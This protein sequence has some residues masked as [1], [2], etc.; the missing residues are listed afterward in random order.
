MKIEKLIL[1]FYKRL[2]LSNTRYFEWTPKSNILLLLG[3]NGAGKSSV[4][5][6][7][8]PCPASKDQFETGGLKEFHC[9]HGGHHYKLVSIYDRGTGKH[10]FLKN[11][12]EELNPGG[13][14]AVQKDLVLEVFGVDRAMH[15]ILIG[16]T[17]FTAM[18]TAKR[19]EVLTRMSP[20]DLTY[21]FSQFNTVKSHQRDAQGVINHKAKR[22]SSENIDLPSDGEMQ[23]HRDQISRLTERLQ[24]LYRV[25]GNEPVQWRR[26]P[27][28]E[29]EYGALRQQGVR[30]LTQQP[31]PPELY[32]LNSQ[33][34]VESLIS[35]ETHKAQAAKGQLEELAHELDELQRQKVP[36]QDFGT[37]EQIQELERELKQKEERLELVYHASNAHDGQWPIVTHDVF[38]HSRGLLAE[39]MSA[40]TTLIQEFPENPNDRFNHQIGTESRQRFA[41][42]KI[43]LDSLSMR[44]NE[45]T[46]RLARLRSCDDVVCPDCTHSFKPGINPGEIAETTEKVTQLAD[47]IAMLEADQAQLKDYIEQYDDYLTYVNR[48]RVLVRQY[49]IYKPIWEKAVERRIM[50]TEPRRYLT[51]VIRWQQFQELYIEQAELQQRI[52]H[53]R[54]TLER[55]ASIDSG[56]MDYL[57]KRQDDLERKIVHVADRQMEQEQKVRNL[58]NIRDGVQS[59]GNAVKSVAGRLEEYMKQVNQQNVDL[60][61][62]GFD[63]EI[64]ATSLNLSD[65]QAKLHR[66]EL[67]EHTLKDIE[68]EH[69]EAVEWHADLALLNKALSPTEGLIGKYL[70]G[71][72]QNVVKLLN[73]VID[74]IWTYPLEVLPSKVDKDELD[75]NF[76]LNVKNGALT[77]PDIAR[78][79]SSQR[80]IVNFAFRLIYM[81]FMG[82]E[83]FPL[84]LDEFG[85]TFD[86]QHRIN[87]I[88]FLNRLIE[89]GQV[90]QL[91]YISHFVSSHGSFNH[92]EVVVL[93]PTNITV[94]PVYNTTVK[95]A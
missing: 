61:R 1:K 24:K 47:T 57:K 12:E 74:E 22:L 69:K 39:L 95:M 4:L 33:S 77:P 67:R 7:L 49:D 73:A 52:A 15:E 25:R 11:G 56:A 9:T 34:Q 75:Y 87:L 70:M 10:S 51:D 78:G 17:P 13:T 38:P 83:E 94:P 30:L 72:M 6:E 63:E 92:A 36:E 48:F 80:D 79:S 64:K 18:P 23:A 5:E 71:F 37:P 85:N 3:S 29:A 2:M 81:K 14:F 46:Q 62:Q 42:N 82:L 32:G 86:E 20:I 65:L 31:N 88:P 27:N 66:F 53:I 60:V 45:A 68:R 16:L 26:L 55:Y 59:Y 40:W 93:D 44:H 21:A 58:R 41:Q 54:E 43:R 8:T 90:S 50:F 35:V 91:I 84:Y 76:P 19:R 89:M 28:F